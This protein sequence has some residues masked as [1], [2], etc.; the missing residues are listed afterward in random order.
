M[1]L[2]TTV[3]S[4]AARALALSLAAGAAR[5]DI[6]P[7][8]IAELPTGAALTAGLQ[9]LVVAPS[10]VSYVTGINGSSSNTD[11][12]TAA[13]GP[14]GAL[15]WSQTFDGTAAWHDQS[16][17][18]ALGPDGVV[19]VTGNTPGPGSYANVLLLEYQAATGALLKTVQYSSGPFTSEHGASVATD[20]QG[21]VFVGG[22]TVGDGADALILKFDAQGVF[23][24]QRVWDGPAFGPFSQ[25]EALKV[26]VD[27]DGDLLVLIHGVMGS[28]HPDYVVVKY[29]GA[30][31]TVLWDTHFGVSG[32]D[33]PSDMELDAAGD[34]YVTGIG[35]DFIDKY[36]TL[37]LRGTDGGLVWQAYDAK[38]HDH[39]ASGL[40][41]DG[42]GGVYVTGAEDPDGDH[43]NFND[44]F[45]T[46]KR[47]AAT[48]AFLWSHSYGANCVG[49]Y[50]VPSD[51]RVD[52]AGHVFVAGVTS[53]PPYSSDQI[54]FVLDALTG[55]ELERGVIPGGPGQQAGSGPLRFD[56]AEN[57]FNAG[58]TYGFD[59]GQTEISLF[60]YTTLSAPLYQLALTPLDAGQP[61]TFSIEHAA[62]GALQFVIWGASGTAT[63]PLSA[64]GV[65]LGVA[66]PFLLF[67]APA[68]GAG[69]LQ[70]TL[71]VPPG[72]TGLTLWLQSVEAGA[73]SPVL[74]RTVQ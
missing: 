46:V 57:L 37:K 17:G 7:E 44:N 16:R 50:D 68:G 61:A 71:T 32:G 33:F 60:K 51:V 40:H 31:G 67:F 64:L 12:L 24:W 34:V 47:D 59:T 23:Q 19:W 62:P 20:S 36:S 6:F 38:G 4:S 70:Q 53:S 18:I 69:T 72:I 74:K 45:F 22:G 48:G 2:R 52:S 1:H 35:I 10:G 43:S 42:A 13:I 14:D 15:L 73:A 11:I 29:N 58:T 56:A 30:D 54:T 3:L 26:L 28:N 55:L 49:C 21:N 66:S 25:D 41:L 39:S 65:E 8:W 63:I 5:A 27:Q 9:G